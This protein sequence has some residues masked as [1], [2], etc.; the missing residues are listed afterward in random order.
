MS[1]ALCFDVDYCRTHFPELH[2]DWVYLANAGGTLA[3]N[4][5]DRK[6]KGIYNLLHDAAQ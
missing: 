1:K 5:S 2:D 3:P 6:I 4:S